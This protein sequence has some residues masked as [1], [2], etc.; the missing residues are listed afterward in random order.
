M[1]HENANPTSS[2][3]VPTNS[4]NFYNYS[5]NSSTPSGTFG[6]QKIQSGVLSITPSNQNRVKTSIA[7]TIFM[8][9]DSN[10]RL[11]GDLRVHNGIVPGGISIPPPGTVSHILTMKDT[12]DP[13]GFK[14]PDG[15]LF[16]DGAIL[17]KN[18]YGALYYYIQDVWNVDPSITNNE[19][20]IPDFRGYFLRCYKND[21]ISG[22]FGA[23]TRKEDTIKK[24]GHYTLV[25]QAG[26]HTHEYW[27][28]EDAALASPP[29]T[30]AGITNSYGFS[31]VYAAY[32]PVPSSAYT[33]YI[34]GGNA[35]ANAIYP[36]NSD[37]G[38]I[39]STSDELTPTPTKVV[40]GENFLQPL[41]IPQV[42]HH[43]IKMGDSK[44]VP[45]TMNSGGTPPIR[46]DGE[47]VCVN[48]KIQTFIKY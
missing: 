27:K 15:W 6:V 21:F 37:G 26:E 12:S 20:Q 4:F 18:E 42:H 28:L 7:G 22:K 36:P 16:C 13:R 43:Y 1:A 34:E 38:S 11:S 29:I 41:S 44:N 8:S 10:G 2:I 35:A 46:P 17:K 39:T 40:L 33:T 14:T 5:T 24:H 47:G 25:H 23:G 30:S 45:L 48:I 3:N 31:G 19:F 32:Q 9:M